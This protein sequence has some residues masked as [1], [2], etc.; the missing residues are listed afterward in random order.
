MFEAK[1]FFD[2]AKWWHRR[3]STTGRRVAASTTRTEA[4]WPW[5]RAA[6]AWWLGT[7]LGARASR[8]RVKAETKLGI[9]TSIAVTCSDNLCTF[10]FYVENRREDGINPK[11]HCKDH[12][13]HFIGSPWKRDAQNAFGFF[14]IETNPD[15]EKIARQKNELMSAYFQ[16]VFRRPWQAGGKW[17]Y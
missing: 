2:Q 8:T 3:W 5:T 6:I 11:S 10:L 13:S 17:R 12:S 15:F 9:L 7:G 16:A 14:K 1:C 4:P